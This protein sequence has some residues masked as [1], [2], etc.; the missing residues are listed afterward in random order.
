MRTFI[1]MSQFNES[2]FQ[3]LYSL[4]LA[5]FACLFCC[6][7]QYRCIDFEQFFFQVLVLIYLF[8]LLGISKLH[9][10]EP[11]TVIY[12]VGQNNLPKF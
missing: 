5:V 4:A 8:R 6:I 11:C 1:F 12:R 2:I 9:F 7:L 3:V 10:F